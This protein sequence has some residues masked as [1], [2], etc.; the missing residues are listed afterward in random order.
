VDGPRFH[1]RK[2]NKFTTET[3]PTTNDRKGHHHDCAFYVPS[4]TKQIQN[5]N[6]RVT[7]CYRPFDDCSWICNDSCM[8]WSTHD[9]RDEETTAMN[10][11]TTVNATCNAGTTR[12]CECD[13]GFFDNP[14]TVCRD[15]HL[16]N[17]HYH[18]WRWC[19]EFYQLRSSLRIRPQRQFGSTR[20]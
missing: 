9:P 18:L 12:I 11:L 10:G 3:T 20:V 4:H 5:G 8:S 2:R 15:T 13:V 16:V 7:S 17:V 6:L 19:F 14:C 1:A